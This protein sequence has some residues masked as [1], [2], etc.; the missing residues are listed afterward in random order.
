M[1]KNVNH[2]INNVIEI[3]HNAPM[4]S[5]LKIAELFNRRP[6]HV[7]RSI[8]TVLIETKHP[9]ICEEIYSD[10]YGRE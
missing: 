8:R 7:L 9:P 3:R 4:V 2:E 1:S 10:K 6:D 5:S